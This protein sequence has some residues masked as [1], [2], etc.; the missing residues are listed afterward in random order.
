MGS[1]HVNIV[2]GNARVGMQVGTNIRDNGD[3]TYLVNGVSVGTPAVSGCG[4]PGADT[5]HYQG[6]R[7]ICSRCGRPLD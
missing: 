5:F 4:C 2:G 6:N 1:E 3:G 7:R